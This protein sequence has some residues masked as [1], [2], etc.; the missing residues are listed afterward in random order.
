MLFRSKPAGG[1]RI[2]PSG[3]VDVFISKGP[4]RFDVPDLTGLD[5]A[6]AEKAL[7]SNSLTLGDSTS[8]FSSQVPAG[9]VVRSNPAAG[10]SVKRNTLVSLVISKGIQQVSIADYKGKVSDQALNELSDAGFDVKQQF[11]YSEDLPA[12][13]V[14]SQIGRAHV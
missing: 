1:G 8:E 7:T 13:I 12:G 2:A 10:A 6:S 14:I 11:V 3:T 5:Q 9:F 4:E